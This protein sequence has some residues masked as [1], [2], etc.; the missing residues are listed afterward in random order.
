M[1]NSGSG[2]LSAGEGAG[3]SSTRRAAY[4]SAK[5]FSSRFLSVMDTGITRPTCRTWQKQK[6]F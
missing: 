3:P 4:S 5:F 6:I 2:A 1:T